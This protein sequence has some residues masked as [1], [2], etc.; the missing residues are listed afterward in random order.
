MGMS[1]KSWNN[2]ANPPRSNPDLIREYRELTEQEQ[3]KWSD[4]IQNLGRL[5]WHPMVKDGWI[6]WEKPVLSPAASSPPSSD[7]S[8]AQGNSSAS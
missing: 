2:E 1:S 7:G 8:T 5:G 3:E 4:S 6:T